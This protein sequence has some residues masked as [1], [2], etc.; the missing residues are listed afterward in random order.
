MKKFLPLILAGALWLCACEAEKAPEKKEEKQQAPAATVE[1][2]VTSCETGEA[3]LCSKD[4]CLQSDCGIEDYYFT[5]KGNVIQRNS[6]L[7]EQDAL[8]IIGRYQVTD[9]GM[10]CQMEKV[11]IVPL[12]YNEDGTPATT[13][14]NKGQYTYLS[15]QEPYLLTKSTCPGVQYSKKYNAN[16]QKALSTQGRS[17][18]GRIY[19][20]DSNWEKRMLEEMRQVKA[21]AEL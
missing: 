13:D 1:L 7:N 5:K 4:S 2:Y 9:S 15:N 16:Q 10:L 8:W 6:C 11:Y 18:V 12:N 19:Y 3:T 20:E 14:Y 17:V 21:L